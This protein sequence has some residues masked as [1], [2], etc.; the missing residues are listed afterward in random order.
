LEFVGLAL[1]VMLELVAVPPGPVTVMVPVVA[2]TGK[3]SDM[4]VEETIV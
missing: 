3:V 1:M 4:E 2:A